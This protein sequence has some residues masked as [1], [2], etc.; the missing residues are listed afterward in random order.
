MTLGAQVLP[1]LHPGLHTAL[2]AGP[3]RHSTR[4]KSRA[5]GARGRRGRWRAGLRAAPAHGT[6][7]R[8]RRRMIPGGPTIMK[9]T[10]A[11]KT[12]IPES[13]KLEI[14]L[15]DD[16]ATGPAD[17]TVEI[18]PAQ[19]SKPTEPAPSSQALTEA[20]QPAHPWI[21]VCR[22]SRYHSGETDLSENVE[23][24]T[25]RR[26]CSDG[27]LSA[28]VLHRHQLPP[29]LSRRRRRASPGRIGL[30]G[31]LRGSSGRPP[32]PRRDSRRD[33]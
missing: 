4:C 31:P 16:V 10:L 27:I 15:P 22:E 13:R 5:K 11:I 20:D 19:Q 6:R 18:E 29:R 33:R 21:R 23:K 7:T 26:Y 12:E 14:Q 3:R 17:V 28:S 1:A 9:T 25:G 2:P 24:F 32:D 8:S 30:G